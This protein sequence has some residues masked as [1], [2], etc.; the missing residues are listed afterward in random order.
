MTELLDKRDDLLGKNIRELEGSLAHS[1]LHR[2]DFLN[3]QTVIARNDRDIRLPLLCLTERV[4]TVCRILNNRS[5][6][7][8]RLRILYLLGCLRT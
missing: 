7:I 1:I 2:N 4:Y 5:D 6:I 3:L 8:L